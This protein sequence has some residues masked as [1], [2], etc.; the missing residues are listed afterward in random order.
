[1]KNL[2]EIAGSAS[3]RPGF[4]EFRETKR[5]CSL[6][7]EYLLKNGTPKS[8]SANGAP[9][10]PE[11]QELKVDVIDYAG[12]EDDIVPAK[13]QEKWFEKHLNHV[14]PRCS[15]LDSIV[16]LF[17]CSNFPIASTVACML[18]GSAGVNEF[19]ARYA[20]LPKANV[21]K[22]T[23]KDMFS[24]YKAFD[25]LAN[26]VDEYYDARFRDY[27]ELI[28]LGVSRE[29]SRGV[30]PTSQYTQFFTKLSLFNLIKFIQFYDDE[31]NLLMKPVIDQMKIVF[32]LGF[33]KIYKLFKNGK[34]TSSEEAWDKFINAGASSKKNLTFRQNSENLE[35]KFGQKHIVAKEDGTP[36][37]GDK[38][39][40][41]VTNY[42]GTM[43][44]PYDAV[45]MSFGVEQN[46][47][48]MQTIESFVQLLIN[49]GHCSP[50]E[51]TTLLFE[52]RVPFFVFRHVIRH[53][54]M[55][56]HR[57]RLINDVYVPEA[58]AEKNKTLMPVAQSKLANSVNVAFKE[59]QSQLAKL[60][61]TKRADD[62]NL[63]LCPAS[64]Y[65]EFNGRIDIHNLVHILNLRTNPAAQYESRM[66]A[67]ALQEIFEQWVPVIYNAFIENK[68]LDP[69]PPRT[70]KRAA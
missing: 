64:Q 2:F 57:W 36:M 25:S 48:S 33:P 38:C 61:M 24:D 41:K 18:N 31:E 44:T 63:L 35:S 19:S 28:D 42:S 29:L 47:S 62:L 1:M 49:L 5:S 11:A 65:V 27:R 7:L 16:V 40:I 15:D 22:G 56:I 46:P 8:V 32:Q 58:R 17:H 26:T 67:Y 45:G 51:L 59:S 23:L 66:F 12:N 70:A 4:A 6:G 60:D 69:I 39:W 68:R 54:T 21:A 13:E 37:D 3:C 52:S 30:L 10:F 53:R 50:F 43:K 14:L 34:L 20:E 55:G 9:V